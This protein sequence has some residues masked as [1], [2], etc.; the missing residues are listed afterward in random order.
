[1]PDTHLALIDPPQ[2]VQTAVVAVVHACQGWQPTEVPLPEHSIAPP[3]SLAVPHQ[4]LTEAQVCSFITHPTEHAWDAVVHTDGR[5]RHRLVCMG[6]AAASA[7]WATS[8]ADHQRH[9]PLLEGDFGMKR[10]KPFG[11]VS[12][13][14]GLIDRLVRLAIG[15]ANN[16]E[17]VVRLVGAMGVPPDEDAASVAVGLFAI[18]GPSD[19]LVTFMREIESQDKAERVERERKM[20][21]SP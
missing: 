3:S 15:K 21:V 4:S 18:A 10:P 2:D 13:N 8:A 20:K 14:Q 6:L 1:M 16:K 5:A 11:D 7:S 9:A 19:R 17:R 12:D